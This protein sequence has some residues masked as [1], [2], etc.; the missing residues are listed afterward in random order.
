VTRAIDSVLE[1]L[2]RG[3]E[4]GGGGGDDVLGSDWIWLSL[5]SL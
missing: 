2:N 4:D 3:D 1:G 5:S